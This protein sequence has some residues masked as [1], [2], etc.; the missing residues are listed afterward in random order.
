MLHES[1]NRCY[2]FDVYVSVKSN[3]DG[4]SPSVKVSL[5]LNRQICEMQIGVVCGPVAENAMWLT[6]YIRGTSIR[7][8]HYYPVLFAFYHDSDSRSYKSLRTWGHLIV[9]NIVGQ[10]YS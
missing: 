5:P 4:L 1:V 9:E 2:S 3:S 7:L 8:V 6:I 10:R